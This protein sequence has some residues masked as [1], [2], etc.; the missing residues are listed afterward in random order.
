MALAWAKPVPVL[1]IEGE[2][3]VTLPKRLERSLFHKRSNVIGHAPIGACHVKEVFNSKEIRLAE[4]DPYAAL[5]SPSYRLLLCGGVLGAIGGEIQAAAVGWEIYMRTDSPAALGM[6]GLA[7]FVPVLL[8]ALPAGQVADHFNRVRVFQVA[9]FASLLASLGLAA[10]SFWQG[11]LELI[12]LFLVITGCA[13]AFSGPARQSLLPLV[14]PTEALSNAVTWNSSGWQIANVAGPALGGSLIGLTENLADFHLAPV[15]LLAATCSLTTISLAF[16]IRPR[17]TNRPL[18]PRNLKTLL[19]GVRFVWNNQPLLAA[20]TLDLFAVLL[21]GA[22]ALLPIYAR[23]ILEVGAFG[24]GCLRAAPAL[25]ASV[26]AVLLAHRPPLARPGRALLLAVAGFGAAT[27]VFG[28]SDNMPVSLAMLIL[29]GAF[30]NVSVVVRS[31]LMQTRTPDEMRGRVVAVNIVFISSS[32]ELGA[33]E[34]GT[35]AAWFG[36]VASVVGGGV[37]T[38]VVVLAAMWRWPRLMQLGKHYEDGR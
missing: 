11:P 35:T 20:I 38:L 13:R 30:D 26:T 37:G 32:N 16:F 5:R 31:T 29:T 2:T 25:G 1:S 28:F 9:L 15:Y 21:G 17:V 12:Y 4:H 34:S 10:M 7:Q 3:F 8:L 36:P 22:T 19:E 18:L 27:I 24:F 14:V 23:D 6:T 33:F